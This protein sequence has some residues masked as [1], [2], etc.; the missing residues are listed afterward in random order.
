MYLLLGFIKPRL[1]GINKAGQPA[2]FMPYN[3]WRFASPK[4]AGQHRACL[5]EAV[6]YYFKHL[7][8]DFKKVHRE[9]VD[10]ANRLSIIPVTPEFVQAMQ[11]DPELYDQLFQ[12]ISASANAL[13]IG[14]YK[15]RRR[16]KICKKYFFAKHPS[17]VVCERPECRRERVNAANRR[18][19]HRRK[20]R[21]KALE[22]FEPENVKAEH[23]AKQSQE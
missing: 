19:Y 17:A 20:Q 8:S 6:N 16:C 9:L 21:E 23:L 11:E 12:S 13:T 18:A 5:I 3:A 15:Y 2:I 22:R 10:E 1:A 4:T 7:A 14:P